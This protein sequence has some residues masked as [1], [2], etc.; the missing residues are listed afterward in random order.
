M[1]GVD[2]ATPCDS[3]TLEEN[4]VLPLLWTHFWYR[5]RPRLRALETLMPPYQR[6]AFSP[7]KRVMYSHKNQILATY[8]CSGHKYTLILQTHLYF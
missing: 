4:C 8:S 1:Q 3:E 5:N 2:R 6:R 7:L